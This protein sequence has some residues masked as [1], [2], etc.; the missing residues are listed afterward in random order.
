MS[1][2]YTLCDYNEISF[3]ITPNIGICRLIPEFYT[4]II[5]YFTGNIKNFIEIDKIKF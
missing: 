5:N 2:I 4:L 3:H 1:K